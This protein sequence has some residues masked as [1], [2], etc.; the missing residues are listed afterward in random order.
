MCAISCVGMHRLYDEIYLRC[1]IWHKAPKQP[2]I[3]SIRYPHVQT[4]FFLVGLGI[5]KEIF[6]YSNAEYASVYYV[7]SAG[8]VANINSHLQIFAQ[9]I[10]GNAFKNRSCVLKEISIS[11]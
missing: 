5:L 8:R 10:E 4:Y 1:K 7:I 11:V 9:F 3:R 6:S 2:D